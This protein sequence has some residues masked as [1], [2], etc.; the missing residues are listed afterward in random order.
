MKPGG[1]DWIGDIPTEWKTKKLR[2]ATTLRSEIGF[3]SEGDT[4]IGLENIES[5]SGK[6]IQTESEYNEG[7]YDIVKKGD[8]LF[9]KLRPYLEKVY[10]S[11]ID[12][13]CTGEFLNFKRFE[14]SK[15]YLYYFLLSP[16]F[17]EIVNASTYG[18][19]MPRAEWDFIKN[20]KLPL[21][22]PAEQQAIAA[23]LDAQCGQIDNIIA[24]MERQIEILKQ[25][26]T[27][28]ITETVTKGLDKAAPQK[29]SGIDWIGKIPEHWEVKRLKYIA[30]LYPQCDLKTLTS[31]TEVTFLQMEYIKDGY[32][33]ENTTK[34][35][36]LNGSYN[37]F[38]NDDILLAKVTPCFENGNI[39]IAKN[40]SNNFGFG[41]SEL[42]VIRAISC[43]NRFLFY[44]FQSHF[45]IDQ[46]ICTMTGVAGLKRISSDFVE[47]YMFGLPPPKEQQAI[48]AFLDKKCE[49]I[50]GII[51]DKRQS[52][53]IMRAYK[54]SLIYEY[55]TG[56][57]RV[58]IT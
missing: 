32:Y 28:L 44:L 11:E 10:I 8:V 22:P 29:R 41:S 20:L 21:P 19:K 47:N 14:G 43:N 40:L 23:F 55:V 27:S 3:F 51:A 56:K 49:D 16:G 57:K 18:A 24:E 5:S 12:G 13:F 46:A 34:L 36:E 33:I 52:I 31:E 42:F 53:E 7:F 39:A 4:Y 2:Y 26:K 58:K 54:K 38:Q 48:A 6:Y 30:V 45:F 1:I 15:R 9:G 17:I 25:Y 37:C 50:A 35:E